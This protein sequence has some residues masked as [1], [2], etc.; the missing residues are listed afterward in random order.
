MPPNS[1]KVVNPKQTVC[2]RSENFWVAFQ[3]SLWG[4]IIILTIYLCP[5]VG[6]LSQSRANGHIIGH[7][8][9][10]LLCTFEPLHHLLLQHYIYVSYLSSQEKFFMMSLRLGFYMHCNLQIS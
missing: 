7:I 4:W 6:P 1:Q 2:V 10:E 5:H 8:G 3:I 9:H